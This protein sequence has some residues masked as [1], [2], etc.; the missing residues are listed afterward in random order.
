MKNTKVLRAIVCEEE[1]DDILVDMETLIQ[2][3][4]IPRS[5]LL[6]MDPKERVWNMRVAA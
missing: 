5:F 4:I 3:S 6:P 1:G 2:W